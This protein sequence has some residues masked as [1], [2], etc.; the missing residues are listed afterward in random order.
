MIYTS[1]F[2]KIL[3]SVI[4]FSF[5]LYYHHRI[6]NELSSLYDAVAMETAL[7]EE[8]EVSIEMDNM[9]EQK[10]EVLCIDTL[11]QVGCNMFI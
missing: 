2:L 10:E 5:Q 9:A 3:I 6:V 1:I 7:S 4:P 8:S 11:K